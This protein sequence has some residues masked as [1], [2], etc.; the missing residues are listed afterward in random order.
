MNGW[1]FAY[2]SQVPTTEG[3][4]QMSWMLK[5]S[6]LWAFGTWG[7]G[8]LPTRRPYC[9]SRKDPPGVIWQRKCDRE[10]EQ[11]A[12]ILDSQQ[13]GIWGRRRKR[14]HDGERERQKAIRTEMLCSGK[15]AAEPCQEVAVIDSTAPGKHSPGCSCLKPGEVLG[16]RLYVHVQGKASESAV[17]C[18]LKHG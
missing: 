7:F 12:Q 6:R 16:L 5:C 4:P 9:G 14:E 15:E 17:P 3:K 18:H 1:C 10:R 8:Y 13:Q 2:E 11:W